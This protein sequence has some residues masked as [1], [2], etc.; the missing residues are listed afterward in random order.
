MNDRLRWVYLSQ[1]WC[2]ILKKSVFGFNDSFAKFTGSVAKGLTAAVN[3][4]N[5][6]EDTLYSKEKIRMSDDPN[7]FGSV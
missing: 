4:K 1:R 6:K 3:D 7:S 2:I 5:F